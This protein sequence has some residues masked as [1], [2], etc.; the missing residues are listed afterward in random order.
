MK[1]AEMKA[2]ELVNLLSQET[3]ILEEKRADYES[4][5]NQY[6]NQFAR[7]CESDGGSERQEAL[8]EQILQELK[9]EMYEAERSLNN[10]ISVVT[11][12]SVAY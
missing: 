3:E 12:I 1:L 9:G 10:Q 5:R 8:R 11:D 7:N 4:A 6:D 2:M